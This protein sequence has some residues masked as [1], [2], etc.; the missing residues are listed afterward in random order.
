M[1]WAGTAVRSGRRRARV[2]ESILYLFRLFWR[3][4]MWVDGRMLC[5][6]GTAIPLDV[7]DLYT[8]LFNTPQRYLHDAPYYKAYYCQLTVRI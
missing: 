1:A 7:M 5:L 2:G 6:S 3:E 4:V 8:R